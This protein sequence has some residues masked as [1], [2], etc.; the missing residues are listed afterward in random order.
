MKTVSHG[1]TR[2]TTPWLNRAEAAQYLDISESTFAR[3]NKTL[4]CPHGGTATCPRYH[5][6]VLTEWFITLE[7]RR[8]N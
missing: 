7:E 6:T 1:S 8:R 5:T 4:P 2:L 3:L